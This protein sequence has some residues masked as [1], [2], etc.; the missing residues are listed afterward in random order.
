MS[1]ILEALRKSEAERRRGQTPDLLTDA[2]PVA[3]AARRT[4]PNWTVLLPV[5]G[6]A[7]IT[8]LLVVWWLR[9]SAEPVSNDTGRDPSV[10]DAR[11]AAHEL[12]TN[13]P[14]TTSTVRA[15]A[16]LSP[17]ENRS[18]APAVAPATLT[19]PVPAPATATAALPPTTATI[20]APATAPAPAV[21]EPKPAL[22]S[23]AQVASLEPPPAP[24][25]TN[26]PAFASPDAPVKLA[27]LSSEDRAQLPTLKVSMHMWSPDAGSRFA[28]IDGTR[29]NEGDRVGEATIEAIQQDS[30]MLSWHGRQIRLPIR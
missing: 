6:A 21:A 11:T 14:P 12:P 10:A 7:L 3:P 8:L 27:D 23:P 16:S 22:P 30:V 5:I 28:I 29:V 9:P 4:P 13:S 17:P 18:S 1:L 19:P 20:R 26:T 24:A 2:I 15:Q 25:S